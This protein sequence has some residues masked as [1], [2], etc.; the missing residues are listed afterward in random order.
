MS[1]HIGSSTIYGT[2]LPNNQA[3]SRIRSVQLSKETKHR[4]KIIEYYLDCRNVNLTCRH[5]GICR[6]YFYKWYRRYNPKYINSLESKSTKPHNVR[7]VTYDIPFVRLIRKLRTDC[8]YL[9][10]KKLARIVFRDYGIKY[11]AS[12]IGRVIKRFELY[13]RAKIVASKKMSQESSTS[14]ETT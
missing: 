6:S 13:F 14:L 1:N 2:I 5:Y 4:L 11:S 9:S 10:S 7:N 8:P 3:L 12:T